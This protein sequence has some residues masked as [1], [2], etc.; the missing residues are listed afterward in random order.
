MRSSTERSDSKFLIS[1]DRTD[2]EKIKC[3]AHETHMLCHANVLSKVQIPTSEVCQ[4]KIFVCKST[5][6]QDY[7][8]EKPPSYMLH[9]KNTCELQLS[10]V[11]FTFYQSVW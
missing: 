2:R 7:F 1:Q 8:V 3:I 5:M 9:E 6:M 4:E 11:N 10:Y